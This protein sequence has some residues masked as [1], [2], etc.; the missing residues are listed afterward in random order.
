MGDSAS[1]AHTKVVFGTL[2]SSGNLTPT[3]NRDRAECSNTYCHGASLSGSKHLTP[4]WTNVDPTQL[5][6]DV[7]HGFPP[8]SP[9]YQGS[10]CEMCHPR[11]VI[12]GKTI[13]LSSGA[14]IDGE[15]TF[16]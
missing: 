1:D 14:H 13:N 9:H 7:C 10:T 5:E 12:S 6:C 11:T 16:F 2:A 3:W 8:P 15:V 4:I